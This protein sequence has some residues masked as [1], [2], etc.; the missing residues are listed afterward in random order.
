MNATFGCTRL[1]YNKFLAQ[2]KELYES[3]KKSL[4]YNTQAKELPSLKNELLFLK[5][6]D[7]IALQQSLKN[8]E[9][10]YKNFFQKIIS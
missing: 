7:S 6:V 4:T 3:E 10:A 9:A 1:I 8:L 2:R 5:E